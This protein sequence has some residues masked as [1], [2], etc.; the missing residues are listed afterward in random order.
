MYVT[1]ESLVLLGGAYSYTAGGQSWFSLI[2]TPSSP[3]VTAM[4]PDHLHPSLPP[5]PATGQASDFVLPKSVFS[6]TFQ[7]VFKKDALFA[8]ELLRELLW[9]PLSSQELSGGETSRT[10]SEGQKETP[11]TPLESWIQKSSN[12]L[13]SQTH[14]AINCHFCLSWLIYVPVTCYPRI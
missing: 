8:L 5:T 9:E 14:E 2:G 10:D 12:T 11:G 6:G 7:L 4:P 3:S 1:D 13:D